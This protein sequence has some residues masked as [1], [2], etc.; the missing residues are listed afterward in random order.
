V[1]IPIAT[2]LLLGASLAN[3][4][5]STSPPD[6]LNPADTLNQQLPYWL[7]FHFEER[8]REETYFNFSF[9]PDYT[10]NY[11]ML[12]SR[13]SMWIE[14]KDWL[15]F[16][17]QTQ[18]AR[19]FGKR[20]Q[21]YG[22]P[23]QDTWDLR[24]AYVEVGDSEKGLGVRVGRQEINLGDERLVGSTPWS[25]TARTF[26]AVRASYRK[27]KYRLD[28]F[29]SSVVILKDGEVG[30]HNAGNNLHGLY[31]GMD[32]VVPNSTIEPYV[33][34]RVSPRI[35]AE[36]GEVGT[37]SYFTFGMRWVGKLP[38]HFDYSTEMA[39]QKGSLGPDRVSAWAGHWVAGYSIPAAAWSPRVYLEY[40]YATGD[41]NPHDGQRNTFDQ[42]YPTAHDKYGMADQVGWKNIEHVRGG[43]E[44]KATSKLALATKLSYYWLADAHDALYNT[45]S[46]AVAQS[47]NGT[48][49][50]FVGKELDGSG[51]YSLTK[52]IGVGIGVGHLFPGGFLKLTTPGRPL[53][54]QY[55]FIDTK[56]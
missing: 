5:T 54:Y 32:N 13:F 27:G 23:F 53:T 9:R 28:A 49:G 17:F 18:D 8:M 19:V 50:R 42:L 14:P 45:S 15:K 7:R 25:N 40:N 3:G 11:A 51:L 33:L 47:V 48:A 41:G 35:K 34:W 38:G 56:F 4:Q 20:Q 10:D 29:A 22:P 21:P 36:L 30:D 44:A 16:R 52:Q 46:T 39:G 55:F 43:L 31:G 24:V 2:L 26:D 6:P 37:L 1:K 12:R